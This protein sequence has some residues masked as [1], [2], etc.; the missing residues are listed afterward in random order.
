M[1]FAKL[2]DEI[3]G[4]F[5]TNEDITIVA[6]ARLPYLTAIISE[7]LRLCPPTPTMLPRLVP[8]DGAMVC[9]N[10]LPGGVGL[11]SALIIHD[12]DKAQRRYPWGSRNGQRSVQSRTLAVLM[13]LY[14]SVG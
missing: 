1:E 5:E 14:Q 13:P 9:G 10:W 11:L 6:T 7:G 12:T 3:R 8:R 2:R 4:A